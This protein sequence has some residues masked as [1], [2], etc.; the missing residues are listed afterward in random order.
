MKKGEE[1][2]GNVEVFDRNR[3][4]DCFIFCLNQSAGVAHVQQTTHIHSQVLG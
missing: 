1:F 3:I 4:S 2:G